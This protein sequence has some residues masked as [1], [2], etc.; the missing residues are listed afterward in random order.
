MA[1]TLRS[2]RFSRPSLPRVSRDL[3][4]QPRVN[5]FPYLHLSLQRLLRE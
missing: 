3:A 5:L 4:R 1:Q 2:V